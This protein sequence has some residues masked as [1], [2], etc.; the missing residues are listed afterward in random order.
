MQ[1]LPE[2]GVKPVQADYFRPDCQKRI[3]FCSKTSKIRACF[4][5]KFKIGACSGFLEVKN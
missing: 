1:T 3:L 4:G 2:R 5:K